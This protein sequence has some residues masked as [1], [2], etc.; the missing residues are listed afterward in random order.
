MFPGSRNGGSNCFLVPHKRPSKRNHWADSSFQVGLWNIRTGASC[1]CRICH[2]VTKLGKGFDWP[3]YVWVYSLYLLTTWL[4]AFRI[5][6]SM[7]LL[8]FILATGLVMQKNKGP[9][10]K[11]LFSPPAKHLSVCI[12]VMKWSRKSGF[13]GSSKVRVGSRFW[14]LQPLKLP[15]IPHPK[16]TLHSKRSLRTLRIQGDRNQTALS[17]SCHSKLCDFD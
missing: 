11:N 6:V 17:K 16:W 8:W 10:R 12:C 5:Y 4:N 13:S 15:A 3:N 14:S 1:A 7:V 2:S 9:V